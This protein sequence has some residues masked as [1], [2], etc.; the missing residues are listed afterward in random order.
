MYVLNTDASVVA[1]SGK[2]HQEHEWKGR[3]V[4]RSIAYGS[5]VLSDIEIKVGA[6]KKCLQ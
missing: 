4:L 6:P 5:K 1:I 2:L 3:T